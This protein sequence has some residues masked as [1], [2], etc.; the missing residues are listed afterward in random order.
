MNFYIRLLVYIYFFGNGLVN[1]EFFSI[2][3]CNAD[4]YFSSHIFF[5]SSKKIGSRIFKEINIFFALVSL[6]I[7]FHTKYSSEVNYINPFCGN[8][9]K[10]VWESFIL[11]LAVSF[12]LPW[13]SFFLI[14]SVTNYATITWY[15]RGIWL[16]FSSY[17]FFKL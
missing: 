5:I 6:C 17:L 15:V 3:T 11:G 10:C 8:M 1:L 4:Y 9:E 14:K 7:K 13:V 12:F 2:N 16:I